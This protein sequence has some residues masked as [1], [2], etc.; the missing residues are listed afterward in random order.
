MVVF[1]NLL[2]TFFV[3]III[4]IGTNGFILFTSHKSV[5]DSGR[6][7]PLGGSNATVGKPLEEEEE[8][9]CDGMSTSSTCACSSVWLPSRT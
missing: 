4:I 5:V 3:I 2:F 1:S 7:H 8:E 9:I 6:F